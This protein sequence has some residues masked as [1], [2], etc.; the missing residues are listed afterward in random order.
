M[1]HEERYR[2]TCEDCYYSGKDGV[3]AGT[4]AVEEEHVIRM[5]RRID[6]SEWTRNKDCKVKPEIVG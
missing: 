5:E 4:H 2:Y 6:P 3:E 1:A